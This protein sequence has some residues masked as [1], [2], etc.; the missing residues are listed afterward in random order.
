MKTYFDRAL[1]GVRTVLGDKS[2]TP[3][4][5]DKLELEPDQPRANPDLYER[6]GLHLLLDESSDVDR[7]VIWLNAWEPEQVAFLQ[8][9]SDRVTRRAP[10]IFLD[11]GSYWGL[12]SLKAYQHGGF[13]RLVAVEADATNFSQLKANLFL[14]GAERSVECHNLAASDRY[15]TVR[16]L[17]SRT[18][19]TGNR[20]GAYILGG[21]PNAH[22]QIVQS[23]PLDQLLPIENERIVA[24]ID[25]EG[26]EV[27]VLRGMINLLAR[28]KC[29]LQVEVL[30]QKADSSL[31]FF[32][33]IGYRIVNV[34][35]VDYYIT[36]MTSD[37]LGL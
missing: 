20:G 17:N 1:R 5:A 13:K 12:Y 27:S 8:D 37:D 18:H 30:P 35:D 26:H 22:G 4:T 16:F 24:K 29:V 25:V 6:M 11:I 10:A 28:N 9:L 23:V 19:P 32:D 15:D 7:S 2:S 14:N 34:I 3:I 33:K 31:P 36:N 21:E